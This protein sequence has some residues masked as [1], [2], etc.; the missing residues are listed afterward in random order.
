M[1]WFPEVERTCR[2]SQ[3][4]HIGCCQRCWESH[5]CSLHAAGLYTSHN[6]GRGGWT[7]SRDPPSQ[8]LNKVSVKPIEK[9]WHQ[10]GECPLRATRAWQLQPCGESREW[11]PK[12]AW[13]C[14]GAFSSSVSFSVFVF[15]FTKRGKFPPLDFKKGKMW[16]S[17]GKKG[18][19]CRISPFFKISLFFA[20]FLFV[21]NLPSGS[22]VAVWLSTKVAGNVHCA[23]FWSVSDH[24]GRMGNPL[25]S[26]QDWRWLA[27]HR[28]VTC[29]L[30]S[31]WK[32]P[33]RIVFLRG[34]KGENGRE[35]FF[36]P[37]FPT[38][39]GK[40]HCALSPG[41]ILGNP[42]RKILNNMSVAR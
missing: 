39:R 35:K 5:R 22:L 8:T 9:V 3:G 13:R 10:L 28:K 36:F 2:G 14:V 7:T 1:D 34:K 20:L 19:K 26:W 18:G 11:R 25:T 41:Q 15:H 4:I 31:L 16:N 6:I 27:G 29:M 38:K 40:K 17:R 42:V 12:A 21:Y 24:F 23:S 37:H 33:S 30:E 32:R